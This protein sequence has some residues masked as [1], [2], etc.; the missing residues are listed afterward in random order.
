VIYGDWTAPRPGK[1]YIAKVAK[2][3]ADGNETAGLRLPDITVP[4]GTYTGW[5]L[6]KS[7]Y[8][9]GELCDRDGT[10]L[11]FAKTKAE[12][13][14]KGDPRPSLEERYGSAATFVDK[15]AAAASELVKARLLLEEDAV[16][17]VE[18]ARTTKAFQ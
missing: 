7:P 9:E 17:Y 11:G 13:E 18:K 1:A 15:T 14:A 3:D 8:P 16:R 12:R 2:V 4:L 6:Y 5:N 10:Y